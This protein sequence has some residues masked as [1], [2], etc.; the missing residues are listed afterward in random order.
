MDD[1]FSWWDRIRASLLLAVIS[2]VGL[3]ALPLPP[4]ITQRDLNNPVIAA[5]VDMWVA[6]LQG[7]GL[8]LTREQLVSGVEALT[9]TPLRTRR[10]LLKPVRPF[11]KA[12]ATG[13]G[14]G[15][16]S[17]PDTRP[18]GLLVEGRTTSSEDWR[19]L[20]DARDPAHR[21][22]SSTL[23][24]RRVI[25]VYGAI[26]NRPRYWTPFVGWVAE[27][28]LADHPELAAVRVLLVRTQ[29]S[30]PGEPPPEYRKERFAIEVPRGEAAP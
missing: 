24:Y 9:V 18:N 4:P 30:L 1:A 26:N 23:H 11:F 28:A 25:G 21:W 10:A 22:L 8:H 16:F 29:V 19:P 5:D 6:L 3:S 14:W 2:V 12:T 13:Q 20:Y 15:L 17:V 27:Q 7:V